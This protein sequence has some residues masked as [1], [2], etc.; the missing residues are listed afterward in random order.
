MSKEIYY[1]HK[2]V[3]QM[4]FAPLQENILNVENSFTLS[5]RSK[6]LSVDHLETPKYG[7]DPTGNIALDSSTQ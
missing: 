5:D 6:E 3:H 2:I 1:L 4:Y 7:E